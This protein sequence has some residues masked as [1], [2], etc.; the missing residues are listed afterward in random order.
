MRRLARGDLLAPHDGKEILTVERFV[1]QQR[2]DDGVELLAVSPKNVLGSAA[3]GLDDVA[4]LFVDH[5]RHV[6]RVVPLIH[7]I[8]ASEERV[9]AAPS[10]GQSPQLL[11]HAVLAN[12][13]PRDLGHA[14]QVATRP[15]RHLVEGEILGNAA[16]EKCGDVVNEFL[17]R[18][19]VLVRFR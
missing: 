5:S 1:N 7:R 4:N 19:E 17:L 16:S 10:D 15:G 8:I 13:R 6:F 2:F 18:H 11:A 14:L 9:V 3:A 12:H